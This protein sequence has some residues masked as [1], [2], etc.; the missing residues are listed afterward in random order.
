M[1]TAPRA[2]L[3]LAVLGTLGLGTVGVAAWSTSWEISRFHTNA[4]AAAMVAG[5]VLWA[6]ATAWVVWRRPRNRWVLGV[7]VLASLGARLVLVPS[8]PDVSGDIN[9]YVW[10]G[11]VQAEGI[12]PYRYP[13][14]DQRL[15]Y[16]RDDTVWPNINH[17]SDPTIYPPVAQ[18]TFGALHQVGLRSIS[19]V[20]L[21]FV[22][23]D[24]LS[25]L[26]IAILLARTKRPPAWCLIYGW[27]PLTLV[28]VGRSGHVDAV[29]VALMLTAFV[30]HTGQRRQWASGA[31]LAAAALVKLY[32]AVLLPALVGMAGRRR[33]QTLGAFGLTAI[34]AYLPFLSVG[35]GVLG[36][37]PGYLEEE[38]FQDGRRY[39]LLTQLQRLTGGLDFGVVTTTRWYPALTLLAVGGVALWCWLRAPTSDRDVVDRGL[40]LMVLVLALGSPSYPWYLLLALALVPLAS[41]AIAA[42][43]AVMASGAT[44]LYL[45]GWLPSQPDW[46]LHLTWGLGAA[47]LIG[48]AAW[49]VFRH[50]RADEVAP[51]TLDVRPVGHSATDS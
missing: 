12:N 37:L 27:H 42:P 21:A 13:P 44:L 33:W 17:I 35:T 32:A 29:A 11:R 39:Y 25:V 22:L 47:T 43:A 24:T 45:H 2:R 36:Y 5:L 8:A 30:V 14:D 4:F 16:L 50:R 3:D 40:L 1:P 18:A 23:V 10:D 19:A 20:K 41:L 49:T 48:S 26:L 6:A 7:I 51:S 31:L 28:E 34:V 9:R 46:P 15:A 38:G